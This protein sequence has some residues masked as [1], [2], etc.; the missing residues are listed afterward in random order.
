MMR[1]RRTVTGRLEISRFPRAAVVADP[2]ATPP[3]E[4]SWLPTRPCSFR[5][6]FEGASNK[7]AQADPSGL[8]PP[9]GLRLNRW[10]DQ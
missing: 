3:C 5:L 8:W 4:R 6:P 9:G 2:A 7:F 10:A 1:L